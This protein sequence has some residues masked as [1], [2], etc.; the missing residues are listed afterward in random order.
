[1]AQRRQH[2]R[3]GARIELSG[4]FVRQKHPRRVGERDG[5]RE[6]LL[7]AAGELRRPPVAAVVEAQLS[8]RPV[9]ASRALG[10][11]ESITDGETG[12]LV[13]PDDAP[14]MAAALRRLVEDQA[15]AT[16]LAEQAR[17]H[18]LDHFSPARYQREVVAV[19]ARLVARSKRR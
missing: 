2:A 3:A 1:M 8:L 15:L 5:D 14:A 16:R 19:L 13:E 18:A 17:R 6:A 4:G 10:H 9:V 12:L 11:L 7:L